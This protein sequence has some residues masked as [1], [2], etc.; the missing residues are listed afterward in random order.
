M[1]YSYERNKLKWIFHTVPHPGEFVYDTWPRDAW[2]NIGAANN[3]NSLG[4]LGSFI[5]SYIVGY[6]NGT[7]GS[8]D[9]SYIFMSVSLLLSAIVTMIAVK[10]S[11]KPEVSGINNADNLI[12]SV[13]PI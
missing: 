2:K 8:F 5:C 12:K 3:I 1:F 6:R 13:S 9:A 4:A 10:P 7:T 11:A